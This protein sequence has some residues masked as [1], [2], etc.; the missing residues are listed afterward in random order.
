MRIEQDLVVPA[1]AD[2]VWAFLMDVPAMAGCIPGA[3]DVQGV[4]DT[5]FNATVKTKIGPVSASFSCKIVVLELNEMAR[6]GT[7]EVSGRDTRI[8]GAVKARMTMTMTEDGEATTVR[9][10]SDVD[11]LGRIGQYGHGMITKRANAM[12]DEFAACVR[13]RLTG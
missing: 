13:A 10:A 11:V 7:V 3:S 5:T 1:P 9:I 6:T 4:D 8:G 2:R 12:L